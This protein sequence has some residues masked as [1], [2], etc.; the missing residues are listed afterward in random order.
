MRYVVFGGNL[1]GVNFKKADLSY[2]DFRDADI[3]GADFT[4]AVLDEAQFKPEQQEMLED[5]LKKA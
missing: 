1:R 2:T 4:G 5:L 3:T